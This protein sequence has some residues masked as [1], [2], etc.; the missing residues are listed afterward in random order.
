MS[1]IEYSKRLKKKI[2][3]ILEPLKVE[4][5]LG[6]IFS[7][8]KLNQLR[9]A[10]TEKYAH[11]TYFFNGGVEE[12]YVGEDRILIPS[13]RIETYDQKPEM[14]ALEL[15]QELIS[16]IKKKKYSF[17]VT[18]FA[19]TDMV[20]HTGNFKATVKAVETVDTCVG[21]ILEQCKKVDIL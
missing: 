14:S 4:N 11:V 1:M 17:I 5:N 9:I 15:T 6:E 21:K 12:S 8:N 7:K 16:S 19:N 3:S 13:P 18:N 10:E 2:I 20:G